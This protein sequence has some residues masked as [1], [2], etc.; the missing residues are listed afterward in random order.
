MEAEIDGQLEFHGGD[1]PSSIAVIAVIPE[2]LMNS[3]RGGSSGSTSVKGAS[4]E[5]VWCDQ[6]RGRLWVMWKDMWMLLAIKNI[7]FYL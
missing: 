6:R 2:Q 4:R 1:S 7:D 5:W 3:D